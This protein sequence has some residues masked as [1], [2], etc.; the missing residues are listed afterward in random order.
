MKDV[1]N[2]NYLAPY[3]INQALIPILRR[4]KNRSAIVNTS[5]CTG[6]YISH[7]NGLYTVT[8]LMLDIYSRTTS[9]ENADK[10]DILSSRPFGVRTPMMNNLKGKL[11]ITAHDCV[12]S[13]LADLEQHTSFTGFLH[14]AIASNFDRLSE[15]ERLKIYDVMFSKF[16]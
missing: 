8:K 2:I 9:L 3:E 15:V 14:K 10:I 1:I 5:S 6:Y 12:L 11:M 7:G 4:R 13:T 16:K